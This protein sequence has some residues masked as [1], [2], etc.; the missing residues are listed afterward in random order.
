MGSVRIALAVDVVAAP[1]A[2]LPSRCWRCRPGFGVAGMSGPARAAA[3]AMAC[4]RSR[5]RGLARA[6]V[7]GAAHRD[8]QRS[9]IISVQHVMVL[10]V[11]LSGSSWVASRAVV[12]GKGLSPIL[13]AAFG[14]GTSALARRAASSSPRAGL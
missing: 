8:A 6:R 13:L 2:G 4:V 5:F 3:S 1:L 12:S 10:L 9:V 11:V 14:S 7:A